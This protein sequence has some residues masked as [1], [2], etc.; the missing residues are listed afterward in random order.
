MKNPSLSPH[1]I[2][3][4]FTP[5]NMQELASHLICTAC[6]IHLT[7]HS[8]HHAPPGHLCPCSDHGLRHLCPPHPMF[9]T[10]APSDRTI[11]L[12]PHS[13]HHTHLHLH[14]SPHVVIRHQSLAILVHGHIRLVTFRSTPRAHVRARSCMHLPTC[15]DPDTPCGHIPLPSLTRVQSSTRHADTARQGSG[16]ACYPPHQGSSYPKMQHTTHQKPYDYHRV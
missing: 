8:M 14:P 6:I 13:I 12:T 2:I 3:Q 5:Q 9:A 15:K 7:P 1:S 16:G 4:P 10:H 11:H